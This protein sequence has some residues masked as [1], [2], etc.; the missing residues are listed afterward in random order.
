MRRELHLAI[1]SAPN[2]TAVPPAIQGVMQSA[3]PADNQTHGPSTDD[4]QTSRRLQTTLPDD[5]PVADPDSSGDD[6]DTKLFALVKRLDATA[7]AQPPPGPKASLSK[8]EDDLDRSSLEGVF[9]SPGTRA[10]AEKR[11][12]TQAAKVTP[13]VPPRGTRAASMVEHERAREALVQ[14]R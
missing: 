2:D 14:R 8:G 11:R 12:R 7:R 13:Y 4:L 10:S 9:P 3:L 6:T 1:L 5:V